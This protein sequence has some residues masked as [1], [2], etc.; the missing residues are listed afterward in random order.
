GQ[1]VT[2]AWRALAL[3]PTW[4]LLAASPAGA[5]RA[6]DYLYI[7][8]SEGAGSGGHAAIACGTRACHFES[9]APGILRLARAPIESIPHRY[10]MFENRTILV[11]HVP[12]PD[13]TY[14]LILDELTRRYLVQH[15]H[16]GDQQALDD[17]RRLLE[18][19][20]AHRLR[21][22]DREPMM[23]RGAGFFY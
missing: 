16:L 22:P 10:G 12:V 11:G 1:V 5:A 3:L 7:D 23:L 19:V 2:G 20:R 21:R 18:A 4:S 17:D 13:E 14:D 8:S 6:I 9:P 15:Q